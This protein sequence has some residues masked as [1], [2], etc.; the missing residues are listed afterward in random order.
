M[1][2][3]CAVIVAAGKGRRMG[4]G[5]NKQFIDIMGRP[6]LYYTL[7]A[8]QRCCSVDEIILVCAAEE[9]D[10]V[11]EEIVKKYGFG[12]VKALVEGGAERQYSV[13]NGLKAAV[14]CGIVLIHDGARPF[15][16]EEIIAEGVRHA[17]QYGAAA[18]GVVPKD[19][20]KVRDESGFS[21]TTL[22]RNRLFLVQTPQCFRLDLIRGC[23]EKAISGE[24]IFTD[25]TSVAEH[26]GHSVFLYEGSYENIKLTTNEDLA[27][28]EAILS[29]LK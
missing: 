27:F 15:V 23:Y 7:D 16:S 17:G 8:F 24:I 26:F 20:V 6:V 11:R 9:L 12:K 19:T 3:V 29:K 14:G 18:C 25:D 13:F 5:K 22:D 21:E 2:K 28:A 10:Y 1:D 4:A